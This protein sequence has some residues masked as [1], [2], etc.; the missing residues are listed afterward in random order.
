MR[1]VSVRFHFWARAT[2]HGGPVH[3]I[4]AFSPLFTHECG[5]T[6]T[7]YFLPGVTREAKLGSQLSRST[8]MRPKWEGNR[9][10]AP[11]NGSAETR[12]TSRPREDSA[13]RAV[14]HIRGSVTGQRGRFTGHSTDTRENEIVFIVYSKTV[15][16]EES[17]IIPP[18]KLIVYDYGHSKILSVAPSAFHFAP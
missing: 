3:D 13:R 1:S 18:G 8:I 12:D 10:T 7:G 2:H 5:S 17:D 6:A 15:R 4:S 11:I 14:P 16:S 9:T